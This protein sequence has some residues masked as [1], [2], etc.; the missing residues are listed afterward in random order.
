MATP[1]KPALG[2]EWIQDMGQLILINHGNPNER[3]ICSTNP[4]NVENV[5]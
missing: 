3:W 2:D 1:E 4:V 5:R